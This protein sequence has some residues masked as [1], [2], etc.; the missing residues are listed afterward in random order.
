MD[1]SGSLRAAGG[2]NPARGR[3]EGFAHDKVA[4]PFDGVFTAT[5]RGI[6]CSE[7]PHANKLHPSPQHPKL[8]KKKE[9]V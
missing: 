7:V 5:R 4:Q 3:G 8:T 6:I 1:P 2:G 9:S